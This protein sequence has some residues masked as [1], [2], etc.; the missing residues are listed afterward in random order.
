MCRPNVSKSCIVQGFIPVNNRFHFDLQSLGSR[1]QQILGVSLMVP[2]HRWRSVGGSQCLCSALLPQLRRAWSSER[3]SQ[4]SN[5][6]KPQWTERAFVLFLENFL[7]LAFTVTWLHAAPLLLCSY[8]GSV[9]GGAGGTVLY[10][11]AAVWEKGGIL[12]TCLW[13]EPKKTTWLFWIFREEKNS[14]RI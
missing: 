14:K 6:L 3:L 2:H 11:S 4:G 5:C 9:G 10:W 7:F 13:M 1:R 12:K 8:P